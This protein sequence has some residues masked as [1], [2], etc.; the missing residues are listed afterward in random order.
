[1][2]R[3]P[4]I[5]TLSETVLTLVKDHAGWAPPIVF[6]LA[7][8]ESLAVISLFLPTT[9]LLLGVG[10]IVRAAGIGLWPIWIAAVLGAVLGDA[11]SYWL[12]YYFKEEI[13]QVWP[14]SRYPTLLP[15]G[16]AFFNKWGVVGVFLGRFSGPLR[17]VMPLIAGACAMPWLRF[18]IGNIASGLIWA[19]GVLLPG[20]LAV[21]WLL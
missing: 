5:S 17:S 12:G 3:R 15:R 16:R 20:S 21:R 2:R 6:V 1:M 8:G 7:F 9:V 13:G 11:V 10:G 18:Q 19:T 14:L 4:A